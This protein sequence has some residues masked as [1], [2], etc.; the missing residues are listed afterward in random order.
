MK[1][2]P[3]VFLNDNSAWVGDTKNNQPN[4]PGWLIE[5]NGTKL[6]G[7]YENG[8]KN[9]VWAIIGSNFKGTCNFKNGIAHG[10][11]VSYYEDKNVILIQKYEHGKHIESETFN[12]DGSYNRE[13]IKEDKHHGKVTMLFKDGKSAELIFKNGEQIKHPKTNDINGAVGDANEDSKK[14]VLW[15]KEFYFDKLRIIQNLTQWTLPDE[16]MQAVKKGKN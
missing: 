16:V 6:K 11:F 7:H 8:E 2:F 9:G 12:E 3:L 13:E 4:G 1:N 14:M 15:V 10:E 5:L